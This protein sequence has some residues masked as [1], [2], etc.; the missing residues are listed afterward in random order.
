MSWL[1]GLP[2]APVART[3]AAGEVLLARFAEA[4]AALYLRSGR[5]AAGILVR[6]QL[7]HRLVTFDQ[8]GWLDAASVL[9]GQA[10]PCDWVA[11]AAVE[12]WAFPA[13]ALRAWQAGQPEAVGMLL[14]DMALA[15][16]RQ[17]DAML[18]LLVQDA[19]ARCAQWLLQH[20][21]RAD[22]GRVG[23][24]LQQRK[25]TIA[26]Q[27]GMAPETLSRV[28]RQLRE[29]G[30]ILQNGARLQLTDPDRLQQLAAP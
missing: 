26:A 12:L 6:G 20:A 11:D 5:V 24:E 16:R 13:Q 17:T 28:L 25:R 22:D 29:R 30:L 2:L 8:P 18:G 14:R 7:R 3:A 9:L 10:S 1:A 4:P 27:L 21:R 23:I 15:Q 19:E